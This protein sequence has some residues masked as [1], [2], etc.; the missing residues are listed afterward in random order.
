MAD[1]QHRA[2][3]EMLHAPVAPESIALFGG[4]ERLLAALVVRTRTVSHAGEG[5]GFL[6]VYLERVTG[7]VVSPAAMRDLLTLLRTGRK[8]RGTRIRNRKIYKRLR[9]NL[10]V[11]PYQP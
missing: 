6:I 7:I 9:P 5:R 3:A 11:G 8:L 2:R 1:V 4:A 10:V